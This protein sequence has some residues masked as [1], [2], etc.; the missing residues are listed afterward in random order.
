MDVSSID[1]DWNSG[2]AMTV[3]ITDEDVN[4]NTKLDN[5]F[6]VSDPAFTTIPAIKIGSPITLG[7]SGDVYINGAGAAVSNVV[8]DSFSDRI[9]VPISSTGVSS[10]VIQNPN[11]TLDDL[12][13]NL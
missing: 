1:G 11:I 7:N 13:G 12:H 6:D 5:D 2:E 4:T 8:V 10:I 3:T 9:I